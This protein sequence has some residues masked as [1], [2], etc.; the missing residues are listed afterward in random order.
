M[1]QDLGAPAGR[2]PDALPPRNAVERVAGQIHRA[3]GALLR[4]NALFAL[5]GAVLTSELLVTYAVQLCDQ[6][7]LA[8]L[9][10][11]PFFLK[12]SAGFAYSQ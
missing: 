8:V 10:C 9:L 2:D 5:K 11:L 12:S 4:G 7:I 1:D 3:G 6:L